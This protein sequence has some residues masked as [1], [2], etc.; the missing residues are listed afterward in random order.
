[1]N[2]MIAINQTDGS[3]NMLQNMEIAARNV[4]RSL[5]NDNSAPALFASLN[6]NPQIGPSASGLTDTDYPSLTGLPL[7]L[8]KL[9]Q[10]KTYNKVPLP[11]E[12]KEHFSRILC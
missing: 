6:V 2:A 10:V 12:I 9:T 8:N 7:A 3:R 1:M 11:P 4:D 5:N